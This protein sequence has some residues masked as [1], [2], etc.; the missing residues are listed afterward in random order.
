MLA[1]MA[2]I[3]S[4]DICNRDFKLE[5]MLIDSD[6]TSIKIADF[7][8]AAE[9]GPRETYLGT[10]GFMAPEIVER[11]EYEGRSVDIYALGVIL[12]AMATKVMPFSSL[13][14]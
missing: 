5:N 11:R 4:N 10:K 3:H 12:F 6:L 13:N 9:I 14:S 2:Y 8:F 1:G 7:G